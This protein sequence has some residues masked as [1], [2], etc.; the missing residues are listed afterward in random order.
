MLAYNHLK[1]IYVGNHWTGVYE[2]LERIR[3]DNA[4]VPQNW[5]SIDLARNHIEGRVVD[6]PH[7]DASP[8]MRMTGVSEGFRCS[9]EIYL[10]RDDEELVLF[11]FDARSP[12]Y[13]KALDEA[14]DT[15]FDSDDEED[16][17]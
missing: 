11:H 4:K 12:Q 16:S 15:L 9:L 13:V 1:K 8:V 3:F 2:G 5:I 6:P 7:P 17:D 14:L 10:K